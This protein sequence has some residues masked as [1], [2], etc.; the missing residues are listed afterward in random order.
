MVDSHDYDAEEV[1]D[2]YR[3]SIIAGTVALAAIALITSGMLAGCVCAAL[4]LA[5]AVRP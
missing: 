1:R 3:A 4:E 5:K 2:A